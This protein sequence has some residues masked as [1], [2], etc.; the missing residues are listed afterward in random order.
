MSMHATDVAML[1]VHRQEGGATTPC[2][3]EVKEVAH[4]LFEAGF[5]K[6]RE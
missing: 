5:D 4:D 3:R 2:L 6:A 1:L